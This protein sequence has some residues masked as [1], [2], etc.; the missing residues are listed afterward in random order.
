MAARRKKAVQEVVIEES[1]ESECESSE[2]GEK[3]AQAHASRTNDE[4]EFEYEWELPAIVP[5]EVLR[6]PTQA[7]ASDKHK[8]LL[9]EQ[10]PPMEKD[11]FE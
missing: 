4:C 9:Q 10:A 11:D 6:S 3:G 1:D 8:A 5:D 7:I 2:P